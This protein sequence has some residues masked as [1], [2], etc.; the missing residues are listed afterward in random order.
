MPRETFFNLAPEKRQR[1]LDSALDEIAAHG[2]DKASVTRIVK[3]AGIATG[4]FYQYFDDVADIF[5]YLGQEAARLKALYMRQELEKDPQPNLE[6]FIRA[7]YRGGLRFGLEH[8]EYYRC[9]QSFLQIRDTSLYTRMLENIDQSDIFLLINRIV[10]QAMENG[11]LADGVTPELLLQLISS[12][13]LTIIEYL[14]SRK[15][16]KQMNIDDLGELCDLGVQIILHGV[17][18]RK[19]Q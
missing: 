9:A 2:Y 11:E 13:N 4:S 10:S 6:G 5:V 19:E 8:E 16:V 3:G 18:K 17:S 15:S 14:L 12:I 1:I 7:M